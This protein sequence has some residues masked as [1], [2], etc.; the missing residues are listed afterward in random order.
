MTELQFYKILFVKLGLKEDE[1][2]WDGDELI[3]SVSILKIEEI[4]KEIFPDDS[5]F[6]LEMRYAS[7]SFSF[8]LCDILDE[9]GINPENILEKRGL[10]NG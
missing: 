5:E 9:Y 2:F 10:K 1:V 7:E 8:G 3:V 4:A 6:Y